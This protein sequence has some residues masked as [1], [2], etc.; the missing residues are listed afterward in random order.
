MLAGQA[1]SLQRFTGST[2]D[3][4]GFQIIHPADID[5]PGLPPANTPA[6][7]VRH[8]DDESHS[9]SSNNPSVDFLEIFEFRADFA[10]PANSSL[11]GPLRV[12]IA[13][14]DSNLCGLSSFQCIP[15][16]GGGIPLDPLREVV[17]WRVQ[18]RNNGAYESMVGSHVTDVDSTDHA[19]VRWWELRRS[20]GSEWSLAQEG[21]YAPDADS[22]WMSS[23]ATDQDGN[24]IVGY[25]VGSASLNAGIRYN[26]RLQGDAPGTLTQ[27]ETTL[28]AGTGV[29]SN[30][31]WGDY[32]SLNVDP[33]DDCTFWYTN[34][35]ALASGAWGT[36]VGKFKFE[37][38]GTPGIVL[39][40]TNLEQS[41]CAPASLAPIIIDV[42]GTAG[43]AGDTALSLPAL[44]AGFT[45]NFS[46]TPVTPPG[47]STLSLSADA[48]V[49]FNHYPIEILATPTGAESQS[50]IA[51]IRA[52]S[53]IPPEVVTLVPVDGASNIAQLAPFIWNPTFQVQ[54]YLLEVDDDPLFGS[55]DL[56]A[57]GTGNSFVASSPLQPLTTYFW[58]VQASNACGAAKATVQSFTTS[59]ANLFC[60]SPNLAFSSNSPV[61]D[62]L[63]VSQN[64]PI[65]RLDV[66]LDVAHTWVG[67]IRLTVTH[68]DTG[69][70]AILI[71]RPGHTP[72]AGGFGCSSNNVLAT[73]SD[74]GLS[75]AEDQCVL[76]PP[77][78][79][80]T[81]TASTPLSAFIDEELSGT[82]T[83]LAED[84]QAGDSGMVNQWCLA[85]TQL[86]EPG[87]IML[88]SSGIFFLLGE[89]A[90]FGRRRKKSR[91]GI[92]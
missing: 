26:G 14:F 16:P 64:G 56:A 32:S 27:G 12:A 69:T 39:N 57:S 54:N 78:I 82:W 92:R 49:N 38:C 59:S 67:D 35:Y 76:T 75:A 58:R 29:H 55:I 10:N 41:I 86:P 81:L 88:L 73:I 89:R 77:A 50:V 83:L 66:T 6:F 20:G 61:S 43:F 7:F 19:G 28:I 48:T 44:P 23:A 21:T 80:G 2:L 65:A 36:Q 9:P 40:A 79:G 33:V 22:R 84:L 17:M 25:S 4:F 70:S 13:E 72:A 8:N 11:T 63:S 42:T 74:Q 71:N 15:Q 90:L 85:P 5:G 60:S 87:S 34:E 30:E 52:F 68:D 51:D 53:I 91:P 47:Q 46:A 3:G 1:A 18:Y 24:L 31:R 37:T 62:V 45:G